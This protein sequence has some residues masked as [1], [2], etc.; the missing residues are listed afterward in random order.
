MLSVPVPVVRLMSPWLTTVPLNPDAVPR[1]VL[2]PWRSM[3]PSA[4]LVS[5]AED[6]NVSPVPD[7]VMVPWL[8][9]ARAKVPF[10]NAT[11]A[12]DATVVVP[13]PDIVPFDQVT[14][15]DNVKF[16]A[17][18]IVPPENTNRLETVFEPDSCHCT[19]EL[20]WTRV[21]PAPANVAPV[22]V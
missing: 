20:F 13:A 18:P 14:G 22:T 10:D 6:K 7:T 19:P 3:T 9:N 15:P 21:M 1:P 11:V 2:S 16:P 4:A 17:P 8:V 12:P 5:A